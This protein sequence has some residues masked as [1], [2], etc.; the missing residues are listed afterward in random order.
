MT[1]RWRYHGPRWKFSEGGQALITFV[2]AL[3]AL[4]VATALA[5]FMI[6]WS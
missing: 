3:A 5:C 1:Q 6:H 2:A 4:Y